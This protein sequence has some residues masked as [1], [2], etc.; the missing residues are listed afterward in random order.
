MTRVIHTGDTHIGYR[1]YHSDERRVDF[2]T[3]FASVIDDAIEMEVDAV[4]HAGDLFHS[5]RP[6]LSDLLD[7]IELLRKLKR[8]D[9]PFLAIV[10]NHE[11]THGDQW[12]DLFERL[13]LAT[14]L[15]FE[16][17]VL[18]NVTLYGLDHVPRSHRNDLELQFDTADSEYA[19]LVAHGLFEPF[20]HANWDTT[21]LLEQSTVS[22][23]LLM[24]GDNH[25]PDRAQ[26]DGTWVTYC[27]ST[28]R[29]SASERDE[30]GYNLIEF[31]DSLRISRRAIET[32]RPFVFIDIEL[33]EGEG[34]GRVET[35][36]SQYDLVDAVAIISISGAG[37]HLSPADV[38]TTALDAGALVARV[39][40]HRTREDDDR[41][42]VRFADPDRAVTDALDSMELSRIG[43]QLDD[44]VR[45][46]SIADSNLRTHAADRI[47]SALTED[48]SDFEPIESPSTETDLASDEAEVQ[49]SASSNE[50]SNELTVDEST[51]TNE[52]VDQRSMEEFL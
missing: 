13:G 52:L 31:G 36:V 1:Q 32:T 5:R 39:T 48:L 51:E 14:R 9:I 50:G 22:F 38:E 2:L 41:Y 4:V 18:G 8:N 17:E 35:V 28:E 46:Q 29:T 40:D 27:G 6:A 47:R 45:H 16:G 19:T 20:A 33:E 12:L 30:R 42:E 24:L 21:S 37:E 25:T 34:L 3:A 44:L 7:T 23:D 43:S 10:G 15:G 49:S 11:R 26:I